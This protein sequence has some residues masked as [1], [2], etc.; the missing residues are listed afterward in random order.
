[1]L[2][3]PSIKREDRTQMKKRI[4][5][6]TLALALI[7]SLSVTAF[8]APRWDNIDDC[9]VALL[10]S[11]STAKCNVIITGKSGTSMMRV[12][13]YLQKV[14]ANGGHTNVETWYEEVKGEK[15][16]LNES[17]TGCASGEYR[18]YVNAMVYNST[19]G[20]EGTVFRV[21]DG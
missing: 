1:M 19:G 3:A 2:I 18:L 12:T 14:N 15:F 4:V 11:G 6:L 7:F 17:V 21:R 8:A 13:V 16:R 10:F 20:S 9:N 5:S